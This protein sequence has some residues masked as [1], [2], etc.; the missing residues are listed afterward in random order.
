MAE[1]YVRVQSN[2]GQL[3]YGLLQADRSVQALNAAP[4][5]GG[6]LTEQVLPVD[7]YHLL[8]P[9]APSKIIG[10]GRNYAAHADE[11]QSALPAEPLLFFKPSTAIIPTEAPILYPA[12]AGQVDYEGELALV[13]GE[14]C[15]ACSPATAANKI[16]G[17][18][19][20]NDITARDL[21]RRDVQWVRAK[22]CD[23][24]CPLGPWLVRELPPDARLQT[25]LNQ[26]SEPVQ[27]AIVSDML[28]CPAD[29]VAYISQAMTLL[30]GDVVLTGT[31]AGVGPLQPGDQVRIEIE[32]IGALE[33]VVLT[34]QTAAPQS[35]TAER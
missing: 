12:M 7:S 15:S 9:C 16:W 30:P 13:I 26:S 14:Q 11:T 18:T 24:F 8:A 29:I 23:S 28:F 33:I 35:E 31:P 4:W 32:G 5:L 19:I 27:Q 6:E 10:V 22:G 21:Q 1:R 2:T 25:F 17:Y 34:R 20:A 3:H